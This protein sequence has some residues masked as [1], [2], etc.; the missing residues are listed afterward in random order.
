[1]NPSTT[2]IITT[3]VHTSF[4][5]LCVSSLSNRDFVIN[6]ILHSIVDKVPIASLP[7]TGAATR[8]I[9]VTKTQNCNRLFAFVEKKERKK[10]TADTP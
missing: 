4:E 3:T 1:M 6:T 7:P 10:A 8:K 2:G 9:F 5:S